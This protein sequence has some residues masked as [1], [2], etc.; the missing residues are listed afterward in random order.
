MAAFLVWSK[1]EMSNVQIWVQ[2]SGLAESRTSFSTELDGFYPCSTSSFPRNLAK[3]PAN[4]QNPTP[5]I[6]YTT[7]RRHMDNK[8]EKRGCGQCGLIAPGDQEDPLG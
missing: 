4:T 8:P 3:G 5:K 2:F 7:K 1:I 6:K